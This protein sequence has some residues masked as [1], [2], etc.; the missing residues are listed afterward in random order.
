MKNLI[1][2]TALISGMVMPFIAAALPQEIDY[3]LYQG[4]TPSVFLNIIRS[5]G[6]WMFAFLIVIAVIFILLA[7]FNYLTAAGDDTKIKKAHK[8]LLYSA[9]AIA[10]GVLA[11]GIIKVVQLI[12][13]G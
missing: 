6:K 3:N 12:A 7:A 8:M 10:V 1:A 5:V 4:Q 13:V 9:V 11:N 2:R